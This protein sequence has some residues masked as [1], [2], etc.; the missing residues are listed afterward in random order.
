MLLSFA[1]ERDSVLMLVF[2]KVLKFSTISF[3]KYKFS[4]FLNACVIEK[5]KKELWLI[6]KLFMSIYS[7]IFF[8]LISKLLSLSLIPIPNAILY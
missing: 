8:L 5:S 2:S 1:H 4:R 7:R 6:T 3:L